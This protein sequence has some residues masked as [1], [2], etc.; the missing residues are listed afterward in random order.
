MEMRRR[1]LLE[2]AYCG[3]FYNSTNKRSKYCT[4]DCQREAAKE[5]NITRQREL[6]EIAK[7]LGRCIVCFK[8]KQDPRY[9]Q[10]LK[11]R[12]Y[13]REW[14]RKNWRKKHDKH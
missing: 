4:R 9:S 1:E 7:E 12:I 5:K 13:S 14:H 11:C 10:C 2:C 8:E 3:S 6:R